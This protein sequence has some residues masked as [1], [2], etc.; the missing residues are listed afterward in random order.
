MKA[1]LEVTLHFERENFKLPFP[2]KCKQPFK[3]IP[4]FPVCLGL[5]ELCGP[6]LPE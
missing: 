5:L 1:I 3:F 6:T 2:M 4:C